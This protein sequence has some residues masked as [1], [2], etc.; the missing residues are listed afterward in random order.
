MRAYGQWGTKDTASTA[1]HL[2]GL[3]RERGDGEGFAVLDPG[4]RAVR[5]CT[6]LQVHIDDPEPACPVVEQHRVCAC[7]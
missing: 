3:F 5:R 7:A 4:G 6:L 2:V 1:L